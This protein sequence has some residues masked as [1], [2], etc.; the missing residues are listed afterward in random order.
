MIQFF[1]KHPHP[2]STWAKVRRAFRCWWT[3]GWYNANE[4]DRLLQEHFEAS[5]QMFGDQPVSGTKVAVTTVADHPVLLVN[6]RTAWKEC[7][8]GELHFIAYAVTNRPFSRLLPCPRS[9]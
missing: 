7:S 9:K 8:R 4:W 2:H 5:E 1:R 3:D 6:Y